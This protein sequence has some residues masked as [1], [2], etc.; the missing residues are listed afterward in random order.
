MP[1]ADGVFV[2]LVTSKSPFALIGPTLPE[3]ESGVPE[4]SPLRNQSTFTFPEGAFAGFGSGVGEPTCT[5]SCTV[6][7]AATTVTAACAA[8]WIVVATFEGRFCSVTVAGAVAWLL[9][10]GLQLEPFPVVHF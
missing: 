10:F 2:K 4:Q 7:P 6:V 1:A 8:L 9:A 5:K 3:F